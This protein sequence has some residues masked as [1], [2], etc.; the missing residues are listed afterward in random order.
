MY[1]CFAGA[2][3]FIVGNGRWFLWLILVPLF[4]MLVCKSVKCLL[5]VSLTVIFLAFLFGMCLLDSVLQPLGRVLFTNGMQPNTGNSGGTEAA[6]GI[7]DIHNTADNSTSNPAVA[8]IERTSRGRASDTAETGHSSVSVC[9]S[10]ASPSSSQ[11]AETEEHTVLRNGSKVDSPSVTLCGTRPS[12]EMDSE[13]VLSDCDA[14]FPDMDEAELESVMAESTSPEVASSAGDAR[15]SPE[16]IASTAPTACVT[17]LADG[18]EARIHDELHL[19]SER[20][21]F[22]DLSSQL[23]SPSSPCGRLQSPAQQVSQSSV[24]RTSACSSAGP[25]LSTG[26]AIGGQRGVLKAVGPSCPSPLATVASGKR[27]GTPLSRPGVFA[28]PRAQPATVANVPPRVI[29]SDVRQP[30]RPAQPRPLVSKQTNIKKKLLKP[31][32]PAMPLP[33]RPPTHS[34]PDATHASVSRAAEE[35]VQ[36]SN[37]TGA[38]SFRMLSGR[39]VKLSEQAL[40]E[41][42]VFMDTFEEGE[43]ETPVRGLKRKSVSPGPPVKHPRPGSSFNAPRPL[44]ESDPS[45]VNHSKP[46]P[47]R[48]GESKVVIS[49]TSFSTFPSAEKSNDVLPAE[50]EEVV[51]LSAEEIDVLSAACISVSPSHP[52][53]HAGAFQASQVTTDGVQINGAH[54]NMHGNASHNH[55]HSGHN[56]ESSASSALPSDPAVRCDVDADELA[57]AGDVLSASF[58]NCTSA[59]SPESVDGSAMVDDLHANQISTSAESNLT[60]TPPETIP[61]SG[62]ANATSDELDQS[63]SA[64]AACSYAQNVSRGA[65]QADASSITDTDVSVSRHSANQSEENLANVSSKPNRE[66]G[67]RSDSD[68]IDYVCKG[69]Q[70]SVSSGD[71]CDRNPPCSGKASQS[72]LDQKKI[73]FDDTCGFGLTQLTEQENLLETASGGLGVCAAVTAATDASPGRDLAESN[74]ASH[75][76]PTA[77]GDQSEHSSEYQA[78]GVSSCDP[79]SHQVSNS[80]DQRQHKHGECSVQGQPMVHSQLSMARRS[81]SCP[82]S[83]AVANTGRIP[84]VSHSS[85]TSPVGV[86][87]TS[88]AAPNQTDLAAAY[89]DFGSPILDRKA[90]SLHGGRDLKCLRPSSADLGHFN[91]PTSEVAET[92]RPIKS[93]LFSDTTFAA[94]SSRQ[95]HDDSGVDCMTKH[96]SVSPP[97]KSPAKEDIDHHS[98]VPSSG[99]NSATKASSTLLVSATSGTNSPA[100]LQT[101]SLGK[102]SSSP[103]PCDAFCC[104]EISDETAIRAVQE[105]MESGDLS[106][107]SPVQTDGDLRKTA[108]DQSCPSVPG[109]PGEGQTGSFSAGF[110]TAAGRRIEVSAKS[111]AVAKDMLQ[112]DEAYKENRCETCSTIASSSVVEQKRTRRGMSPRET[113]RDSQPP[114]VG[115]ARAA[116]QSVSVSQKSLTFAH[117]LLKDSKNDVAVGHYNSSDDVQGHEHSV[118]S[119]DGQKRLTPSQ[120]HEDLQKAQGGEAS[121]VIGE[122]AQDSS[123]FSKPAGFTTAKGQTISVS[124]QSFQR[125][126]K[127]L[128]ETDA[129]QLQKPTESTSSVGF[130]GFKTARGHSVS[131]SAKALKR[132]HSLMTSVDVPQDWSVSQSVDESDF[133]PPSKAVLASLAGPECKDG[134]SKA[135]GGSCLEPSQNVSDPKKDFQPSPSVL[136]NIPD[137]ASTAAGFS[138]GFSTAGGRKVHVSEKALK[139]ARSFLDEEKASGPSE[140]DSQ[141]EASDF[142]CGFSTAAGRKVSVS[143]EAMKQAQYL[144][145]DD[146]VSDSAADKKSEGGFPGFATARGRKVSVSDK[147]LEQARSLLDSGKDESLAPLD[148]QKPFNGFATAGGRKVPVSEKALFQARS[149]LAE[150]D[151]S[152]TMVEKPPPTQAVSPSGVGRND[153]VFAVAGSKNN[154]ETSVVSATALSSGFPGF[155]TASGGKVSVSEEA[156]KRARRLM[157]DGESASAVLDKGALGVGASASK[158]VAAPETT[159]SAGFTST[160]GKSVSVSKEAMVHAQNLLRE[161]GNLSSNPQS[162]TSGSRS[163]V[164]GTGNSLTASRNSSS[165]CDFGKCCCLVSWP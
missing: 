47:D 85:Q 18:Y 164:R 20:A 148:K 141:V 99:F 125:A 63:S 30:A 48:E 66:S 24:V 158:N 128:S 133:A 115:I 162:L 17:P 134:A 5:F 83:P 29:Y 36:S 114:E 81:I 152:S 155:A 132:A 71:A 58:G 64:V 140:V 45:V 79:L 137:S 146:S 130:S 50:L 107:A 68:A 103:S 116:D 89:T 113:P 119:P 28:Y 27:V 31:S 117:E 41:A 92:P 118:A 19:F 150:R 121:T 143:K 76:V 39:S 6:V 94:E 26:T 52:S 160:C 12:T 153:T 40:K 163:A 157:D 112:D 32:P 2:M 84:T 138:V 88:H 7:P 95:S 108:V 22:A 42:K 109:L 144:L 75:S 120:S 35:V 8:V 98:P 111:L 93:Y 73:C 53:S 142:S 3:Y 65:L 106:L 1:F 77:K 80:R 91:P 34:S 156:L 60:L 110:K 49:S 59:F 25:L 10:A 11:D 43:K 13:K 105:C 38:A 165:T 62:D 56:C 23:Y 33:P 100:A 149:L 67:D 78:L 161:D 101:V 46:D 159:G 44:V 96:S 9:P 16:M 74:A 126:Q 51:G 104:D 139:L 4:V 147:A 127:I 122:S 102:R 15:S 97:P 90:L 145:A 70:D 69:I 37:K 123:G 21:L 129:A 151:S 72:A 124:N 55:E 154:A 87:R 135:S 86:K 82:N 57:A 136:R 54:N 14:S 131:V 61:S